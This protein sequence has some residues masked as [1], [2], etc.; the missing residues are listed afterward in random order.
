MKRE[1]GSRVISLL[2]DRFRSGLGDTVAWFREQMPDYYFRTTSDPEQVR[3]LEILHA[4]RRMPD[5]KL[6]ML[7]DTEAQKFLVIGR[8]SPDALREA[9][10]LLGDRTFTRIAIHT[11]DDRS[12]AIFAFI[13]GDQAPPDDFN[14]QG[15]RDAILQGCCTG[16]NCIPRH[17]VK[18]YLDAVD[19]GYLARS[20]PERVA[21]HV[22]A[23]R[24]IEDPES[25]HIEIDEHTDDVGRKVTRVLFAGRFDRGEYMR[26]LARMLQRNHL[27]LERGYLDLVPPPTGDGTL[28][29][30][31]I[32]VTDVN[33]KPLGRRGTKRVLEEMQGLHR[34]FSDTLG[35]V[36][37]Q[38]HYEQHHFEALV[39]AIDFASQILHA[40]H[41]FLDVREVGRDALIDHHE[42]CRR[43][44]NLI[45]EGFGKKARSSRGWKRLHAT[46][47][48]E[49]SELEDAG[50]AT[51]L[52]CMLA[53]ITSITATNLFNRQRLGQCFQLDPSIL[54]EEQFRQKPYGIF[55]FHG[56]NGMGFQVRFRA[57]AR[58]GL[59]LLTPRTNE[60]LSRVRN[61]LLREVYDLAWAQQLKN[62]DIPEGGSKCI[63]LVRP[64][65]DVDR[66]VKQLT[67][68]LLDL[69]LP[70][71]R[72]PMITGPHGAKRKDELIF[73]G[74][75]ENM[76]PSRIEWVA[77]RARFRGLPHHLTLMSSKPGSG[78]NHKEYGVTSEGIYTW[79]PHV[80]REVGI[81]EKDSWTLKITGGPDGDVGGNLLKI[82]AREQRKRCKVIAIADGSGCAYD[83]LGLDWREL[84]SLVKRGAAIG[85]FRKDRLRGE[86]SHVTLANDRAG[87]DLRNNL[88]NTVTADVF[89][90]C[91]GR[92]YTI[93]D[94]NWR[95]F[96]DSA[97]QPSA[98]AMIE[99]ANIFITTDA[100]LALQAW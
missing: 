84:L 59:R 83:P 35:R 29:I 100:R 23:W 5:A 54:P 46:I 13:Y 42:L 95:D 64:G 61:K 17:I 22:T 73:L 57:S 53:F 41:S 24:S 69:I 3:H 78:I 76:T 40:E 96:C 50:A 43:M 36:Y 79:I 90:P 88:H 65:G 30:S 32:Y 49:I 31:T 77:E 4:M 16:V 2:E 51:V 63:A 25:V 47:S 97:G 87:E 15:H 28:L 44:A 19:K 55:Y 89:V 45:D 67:D 39:A 98:R 58:G 72:M 9:L 34:A 26:L 8:P 11:A 86:G 20:Y 91:G 18:R 56:N 85:E 81:G 80:L 74:P 94:R 71:K 75:D 66:M 27:F 48:E 93:N 7:D 52:E 99:G 68:S 14:W 6:T 37:D 10:Y 1:L 60:Q 70:P 62:K 38:T 12:L 21:R 92:P 82:L 33:G